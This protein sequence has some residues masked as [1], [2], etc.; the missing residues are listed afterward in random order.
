M[1]YDIY[2]LKNIIKR[3]M[4]IILHMRVPL[5]F[6]PC[7]TI[8]WGERG[9]AP[10]ST[11]SLSPCDYATY[12]NM[13]DSLI[14]NM[15]CIYLYIYIYIYIIGGGGGATF[16]FSHFSYFF[17]NHINMTYPHFATI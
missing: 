3:K 17:S 8:T 7:G 12:A 1:Q 5:I 13:R 14:C 9:W 11:N 15:M 4:H 16:T 6:A 10:H 2:V